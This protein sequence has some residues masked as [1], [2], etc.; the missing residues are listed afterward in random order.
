V[1]NDTRRSEQ[2]GNAAVALNPD[3][4]LAHNNLS[5]V[6]WRLGHSELA[7][8]EAGTGL[9][10]LNDDAGVELDQR[11]LGNMH[12]VLAEEVDAALGDY[13]GAVREMRADIAIERAGL[14]TRSQAFLIRDLALMHDLVTARRIMIDPLPPGSTST[15]NRQLVLT[16]LGH[17]LLDIEANNWIAAKIELSKAT[18]SLGPHYASFQLQAQLAFVLAKLGDVSSARAFAATLRP[19]CYPC[20]VAG[21]KIE[22]ISRDWRAADALFS[23]AVQLGP[24]LPFAYADWGAMLLT[25]GK[26]DAAIAK[27]TIAHEKGPHFAD[28]LEMWGEALIEKNRSDLALGKFEEADKYAPNWGRLHLEWGKAFLYTGNR[29]EAQ[30]QLVL[31]ARLDLS[32][33]DAAALVGLRG[34]HV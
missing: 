1:E 5:A 4:L 22:A 34:Q 3:L 8:R 27:F 7:Y 18:E 25:R 21:A 2:Y 31:A 19:D 12:S 28:P 16:S 23:D 9:K 15:A 20:V 10:L 29:A 14:R 11:V 30:K 24:S 6:A 32:A 33:A 17:G 13:A 26:Y